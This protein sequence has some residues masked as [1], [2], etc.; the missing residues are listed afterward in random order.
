MRININT[1]LIKHEYLIVDPSLGLLMFQDSVIGFL[2]RNP[3][4]DICVDLK[5]ELDYDVKSK[6][7]IIIEKWV[8]DSKEFE[9][10]K[11]EAEVKELNDK[12]RSIL[13]PWKE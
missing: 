1:P 2:T 5:G 3:N 8:K 13:A 9:R 12:L 11:R 7:K 10:N 6:L 4:K